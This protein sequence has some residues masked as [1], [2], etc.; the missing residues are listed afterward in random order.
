VGDCEALALEDRLDQATLRR[1]V[2]DD[3]DRFGHLKTPNRTGH[4]LF[5]SGAPLSRIDT[6]QA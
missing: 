6:A 1:I 4:R 2:V 5:V 3:E